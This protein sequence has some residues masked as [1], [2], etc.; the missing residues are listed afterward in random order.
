MLQSASGNC[1]KGEIFLR[2]V[3][4]PV[5]GNHIARETWGKDQS[6]YYW[7]EILIADTK[8]HVLSRLFGCSGQFSEGPTSPLP[9]SFLP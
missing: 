9:I 4:D 8:Q 2:D 5:Q 3:I 6:I 7:T 1:R